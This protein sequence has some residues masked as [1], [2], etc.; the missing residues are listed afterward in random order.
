MVKSAIRTIVRVVAAFGFLIA[1]TLVYFVYV[2][3]QTERRT[4]S[5]HA[6]IQVDEPLGRVLTGPSFLEATPPTFGSSISAKKPGPAGASDHCLWILR[7]SNGTLHV[8]G[9][10]T[11]GSVLPLTDLSG[12]LANH[13]SDLEACDQMD[14]TVQAYGWVWRGTVT[15]DYDT[16][17]TVRSVRQPVYWD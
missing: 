9:K 10:D 14:F 12:Y 4:Q 1:A 17:L 5:L 11:E 3:N 15:V 16:S 8:K 2:M 7:D 13:T 6:A